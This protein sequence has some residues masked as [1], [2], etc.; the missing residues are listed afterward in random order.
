MGL[1]AHY[2]EEVA[3]QPPMRSIVFGEAVYRGTPDRPFP[4]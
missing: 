4:R 3:T 1:S 2:Y